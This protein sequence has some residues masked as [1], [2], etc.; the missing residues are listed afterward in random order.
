[1]RDHVIRC[2]PWRLLGVEMCLGFGLV[3]ISI[4]AC[5]HE[6]R[7]VMHKVGLVG[8]MILSVEARGAS[9]E[10]LAL[11]GRLESDLSAPAMS[12]QADSA[13]V[14][15]EHK[16]AGV[17]IHRAPSQG[18]VPFRLSMNPVLVH[19]GLDAHVLWLCG[20]RRAPA[21]WSGPAQ[22]VVDGLSP[23]QLPAVCR[24]AIE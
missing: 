18:G 12:P 6:V 4:G 22:A 14:R 3:V 19:D 24:G 10:H 8:P 23:Q 1:M 21:G 2:S 7:L 17:V 15:F 5:L 16:D 13:P 20:S 11:T 9:I